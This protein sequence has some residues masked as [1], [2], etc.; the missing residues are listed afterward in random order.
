MS[1]MLVNQSR[2][3]LNPLFTDLVNYTGQKCTTLFLIHAFKHIISSCT[4][5]KGQLCS[6]E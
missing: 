1:K 6:S 4:N 5:C 2:G 3:V